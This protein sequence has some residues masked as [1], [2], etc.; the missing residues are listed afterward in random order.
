MNS[1]PSPRIF[2]L[3]L[4]SQRFW[5]VCIVPSP[6][7]HTIHL[8]TVKQIS[9]SFS[10]WCRYG[11]PLVPSLGKF[12]PVSLSC[13]SASSA[14]CS[15]CSGITLQGAPCYQVLFKQI[16]E[17]R[18]LVEIFR[19]YAWLWWPCAGMGSQADSS[20]V[21]HS[22]LHP[23][24][25]SILAQPWDTVLCFLHMLKLLR[26]KTVGMDFWYDHILSHT[27]KMYIFIICLFQKNII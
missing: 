3:V 10:L 12:L 8:K 22:F 26:K 5:K 2:V 11:F 21:L 23:P 20:W 1:D 24:F 13:L 27:P 16:Q 15:P 25:S 4:R 7:I 9:L 18:R 19:A 6:L 17:R 14:G